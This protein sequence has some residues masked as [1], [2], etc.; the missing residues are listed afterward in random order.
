[1]TEVKKHIDDM[2]KSGIIEKAETPY[3]SHP[4]IVQKMETSFRFCI[5]NRRL[6]ESATWPLP[7]ISQLFD[8]ICAHRPNTFGVMDLTS[9]YHQAP[10]ALAARKLT[11]FLCFAGLFQFTRLPFGP[12]RVPSYFQGQM[13]SDVL[14]G[15]VYVICEIYLVDIIIYANG[16]EEFLARTRQVFE[17]LRTKGIHLKA[18]K[19]KLGLP[20]IEYVRN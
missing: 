20:K 7:N 17:R 4:V 8:R 13:V 11:A 3:Y 19:T 14:A 2:M 10:F 5:D 1:M 6:N 12:K 15:L 16:N 9:G 18:K